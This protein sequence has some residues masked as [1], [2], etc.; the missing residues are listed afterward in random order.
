VTP[1]LQADN[2]RLSRSVQ[3]SGKKGA[4]VRASLARLMRTA[5]KVEQAF[6]RNLHSLVGTRLAFAN[7][8]SYLAAMHRHLAMLRRSTRRRGMKMIS[9]NTFTIHAGCNLVRTGLHASKRWHG[10]CRSKRM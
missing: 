2:T 5:P 9:S 8:R 3:A 4:Y 7:K 1:L 10:T 6:S